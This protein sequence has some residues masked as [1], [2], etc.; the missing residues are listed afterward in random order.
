MSK[1]ILNILIIHLN[2]FVNQVIKIQPE[3]KETLEEYY[4]DIL[5]EETCN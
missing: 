4:K 3:Y 2:F 5:E 1:I